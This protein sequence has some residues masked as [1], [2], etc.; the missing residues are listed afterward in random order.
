V[1]GTDIG[2]QAKQILVR[3]P[4]VRLIVGIEVEPAIVPVVV[5]I[6][7]HRQNRLYAIY[8]IGQLLQKRYRIR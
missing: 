7:I 2:I 5:A 8:K 6:A 1:E 3:F 4:V